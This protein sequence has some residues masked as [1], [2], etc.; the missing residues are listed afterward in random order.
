M[1]LLLDNQ[2]YIEDYEAPETVT[3]SGI[4]TELGLRQNH[5]SRALS[6]LDS[7]GLVISRTSHIK[8]QTRRKKVYFL[9]QKGVEDIQDYIDEISTNMVLVHDE[10]GRL[11]E[12]SVGKVRDKLETDL[13]RNISIHQLLW[14]Y[15]TGSEIDFRNITE[16]EDDNIPQMKRFYGRRHEIELIKWGID[17][18]DYKFII[19][20]SI[21]G[22]GKTALLSELVKELKGKTVHF[23]SLNEWTS[24]SSLLSEWAQFLKMRGCRALHNQ[25][26]SSAKE[27]MQEELKKLALD[28]RACSPILIL[29]DFHKASDQIT[30]MMKRVK[31]LLKPGPVFL[32]AS[33]E[34]PG[35][36][37]KKDVLVEKS[38][39]EIKLEGLTKEEAGFMLVDKGLPESE[40]ETAY[41]YTRGHPLA[42]ELY[43]PL[44][45]TDSENPNMEFEAFIGE[46]IIRELSEPEEKILKLASLLQVPVA[47][48]AFLFDKDITVDMVEGL[49]EKNILRTYK[50]G[51]LDV[52][53]LIRSYFQN[54]L[55]PDEWNIYLDIACDH[56]STLGSDQDTLEYLRLLREAER[57]G[58]FSETILE[59]G[60]QLLSQGYTQV[61]DFIEDIQIEDLKGIDKAKMLLLRSDVQFSQ[62][63]TVQARNGLEKALE[64]CDGLVGRK[65]NEEVVK[66]V[67]KIYNRS[68]EMAKS[69][70]SLDRTVKDQLKA[71]KHNREFGDKA[72][73]GKTLNNL[74]LT[75]R[76]RG[77]LDKALKTLNNARA[78]F[79]D[80]GDQNAYALV[81]ANIGDLFLLKRD[82][83]TARKLFNSARK[84]NLRYAPVKAQVN[85]KVGRAYMHM[86]DMKTAMKAL[87]DS[88]GSFKDARDVNGRIVCTNELFR[89]ACASGDKKKA[90][91]YLE[92]VKTL[93]ES[94]E[95][96][97]QASRKEDILFDQMLYGS[98]WEKG[99][100]SKYVEDYIQYLFASQGPK[101]IMQTIDRI[102][103]DLS[104]QPELLLKIYAKAD[105]KFEELGE[106]HPRV[107]L[108]LRKAELLSE[109]NGSKAEKAV[110]EAKKIAEKI[111]FKP[112]VAKAVG[113]LKKLSSK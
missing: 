12:E 5:V 35:F 109:E 66:L 41:D 21:A 56:F 77:Q 46:E 99:R 2:R 17:S 20:N 10:G 104:D 6:E 81:E 29:D 34:K 26:D 103:K 25:L 15:Y 22:Q 63:R 102:G 18:G 30:E 64:V 86:G 4:S 113:M 32:I 69:E 52:H 70:G 80:L 61:G 89:C 79:K 14:M 96:S 111:G 73:E 94:L 107:I 23:F 16:E 9:S 85:L 95:R 49:M 31:D 36:Y 62:G 48:R 8:E 1:L 37:S 40:I 13:E 101:E 24:T 38:V 44:T 105:K 83:P 7:E 72:G 43:N 84:V 82:L 98:L 88:L 54:R 108:H 106:N 58:Q 45:L 78:I 60:D 71:L 90:L 87:N 65:K 112:G 51:T 3:Q 55:S 110:K 93:I 11:Y 28:L 39:L 47:T 97:G 74:G 33:R 59:A 92:T 50:A 53:D 67:S 75:Y 27:D 100:S 68:A 91:S 19:V 57:W 42:L 76:D